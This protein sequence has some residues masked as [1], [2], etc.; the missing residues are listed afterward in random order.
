MHRSGGCGPHNWGEGIDVVVLF[1]F[2]VCL[3]MFYPINMVCF[4]NVYFFFKGIDGR[5]GEAWRSFMFIIYK[6][7]Y[8][9]GFPYVRMG[10]N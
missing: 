6:Y 1:L 8:I 10:L 2:V 4:F 5:I 3:I 9:D 7:I